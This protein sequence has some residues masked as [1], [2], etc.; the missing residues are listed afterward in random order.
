MSGRTSKKDVYDERLLLPK[1]L[2][3]MAFGIS[4]QAFDKWNLKPIA[5]DGREALF[6][7]PEVVAHRLARESKQENQINLQK[8]V[9]RLN[10]AKADH[11]ERKVA[12]LDGK[13]LPADKVEEVWSGMIMACRAKILPIPTK[14]ALQL[15]MESDP[16][17]VEEALREECDGALEELSE[18][19][20]E[21]YGVGGD[22]GLQDGPGSDEEDRTPA[23]DPSQ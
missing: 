8:E 5:R 9:A 12:I 6:Y 15:S 19:D 11:E 17:K 23:T 1:K 14:L 13:L 20:P 22:S 4:V 18:Y 7:L 10:K 2:M 3:A 21:Q 16:V